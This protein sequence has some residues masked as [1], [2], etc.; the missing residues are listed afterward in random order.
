MRRAL[1]ALG[2]AFGPVRV[3]D[4]LPAA[5]QGFDLLACPLCEHG[6]LCPMDWGIAD[7]THWWIT[8]RCPECDV[9]SEIVVTNEQA[10]VLDRVLDRQ[11]AE[12]S[13]ELH[14]LD[15][16]RMAYEGEAFVQAL[17][18]DLLDAGDFAR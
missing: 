2:R 7:D 9:W 3:A 12:M 15:G 18:R 11:M 4:A 8:M 6:T 14:R 1:K 10:A 13:A 5:P 17:R 16:E